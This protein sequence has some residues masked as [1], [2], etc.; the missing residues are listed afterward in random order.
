MEF[1]TFLAGAVIALNIIGAIWLGIL[2]G[3]PFLIPLGYLIF[4]IVLCLLPINADVA[5]WIFG[6]IFIGVAVVTLIAIIV[7]VIQFFY[8][9][10]SDKKYEKQKTLLNKNLLEAVKI[11]DTENVQRLIENGADPNYMDVID[12]KKVFPLLI[13]IENNDKEIV[14]LL[15]KKDARINVFYGDET[16]LMMAIKKKE[17]LMLSMTEEKSTL[18]LADNDD[19]VSLLRSHGAKT[20][21][22][23]DEIA[24]EERRRKELQYKLNEDLLTAIQK[25][26][27]VIAQALIYRGADV[28]Y[29]PTNGVTPLI[30]AIRYKDMEMIKLLLKNGADALKKNPIGYSGH[31]VN[32][33]DY[34]RYWEKDE[35]LAQFI[36]FAC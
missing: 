15:I 25:H 5:M 17:T 36:E 21:A 14:S 2:M 11:G 26:E 27:L 8:D 20:K 32:A 31:E 34:A 12:N 18:D 29:V 10:I 3:A 9:I 30:F 22:E 35:Y 28:N 13:A 6:I 4:L 7:S 33:I 19:I 1:G 23:L 16:P 24:E